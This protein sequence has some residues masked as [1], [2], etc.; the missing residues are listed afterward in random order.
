MKGDLKQL[1][2]KLQIFYFK[3]QDLDVCKAKKL[4][5]VYWVW[6]I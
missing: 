2:L 3:M 6:F 1:S 5:K 4:I